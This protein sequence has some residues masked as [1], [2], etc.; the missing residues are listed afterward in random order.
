V[1]LSRAA[2]AAAGLLFAAC[3]QLRPPPP[4]LAP[5]A[6][7]PRPPSGPVIGVASW[8]GPGFD[9]RRTSS[10]EVYNQEDLTAASSIYA[11]GSRVMVTNLDN[12]R[13]VVVTINDHGPF[14][15]GRKV[16]LSKKAA[17]VIGMIGPGTAP[18]RID[19]LN[20]PAGS[21]PV[22][23]PQYYVQVGSF[24]NSSNAA[25]LREQLVAYY[26]DVRIDPVDAGARRYYRV[27]MGAFS[28]RGAA[29]SRAAATT[30]LGLPV[31][32]VTE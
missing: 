14:V 26:P 20:A 25:R 18:V 23:P 9:G 7:A 22:G 32:I 27:R 30:R 17:R 31:V 5:P 3:S 24:A 28:S 21:R 16:D 6:P 13:S 15:K 12:D 8:Y 1:I 11:L 10:G 4:S 29:E 2:L 19:L